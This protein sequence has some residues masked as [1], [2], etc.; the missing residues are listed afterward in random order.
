M[1]VEAAKSRQQPPWIVPTPKSVPVLK[2]Q[3]SLTKT[4]VNSTRLFVR[5]SL[6]NSTCRP[7]LF[8]RMVDVLLGTTVVLQYTM[9]L[10]WDTPEL[11]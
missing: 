4:K 8:Q 10:T 1:S 5:L 9:P 7:S 3:N 6:T 2:F 11:T